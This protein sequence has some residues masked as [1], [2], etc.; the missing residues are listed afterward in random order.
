[1]S[2]KKMRQWKCFKCDCD[3]LEKPDDIRSGDLDNYC[4][5]AGL[6]GEK[7]LNSYS[8]DE[9]HRL[10]VKFLLEGDKMK[11]KYNKP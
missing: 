2:D 5:Y 6:C 8:K 11:R 10:S 3:Y 4:R 7:C 9:Q 1:M